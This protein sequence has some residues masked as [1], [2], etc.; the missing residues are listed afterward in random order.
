MSEN[1]SEK[2]VKVFILSDS[3]SDAKDHIMYYLEQGHGKSKE[4]FTRPVES[5]RYETKLDDVTLSAVVYRL[6]LRSSLL[7]FVAYAMLI[8]VFFPP[9]SSSLGMVNVIRG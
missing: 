6:F 5:Y 9:S 8:I 7:F 4:Y 3:E 1:S 2:E